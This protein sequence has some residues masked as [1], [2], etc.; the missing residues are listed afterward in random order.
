M[1][2]RRKTAL[3]A[4][5][6]TIAVLIA[7]N[8][9]WW[10]YYQSISSYLETQL[11]RRLTGVAA[12]VALHIEPLQVEDLLLD[13]L[14]TYAEV[15]MYL[16]SLATIDSLSEASIIDIDF[17]YL[18]SSRLD[19]PSQGYLLARTNF[20][21]LQEAIGG[22]PTASPLYNVDGTYLKSAYAPLYGIDSTVAAL[23]VTEAGA[24]Y[25]TLLEAL[26]GNLF[27][28]A[29]GSAAAVAVL[30]VI[31]ILFNRRLAMAEERIIQAGTQAALGR[32]VAVVSH[33]VKNPLMI[34]RAAGERLGKKYDDP[35]ASFIVEEVARLDSIVTGYL[36]FARGDLSLN[37]EMVSLT[38]II[39]QI[40]RQFGRQ[41]AE[42]SVELGV[43]LEETE[44][45]LPADNVALRQVLINLLLNALQAAADNDT[46]EQKMVALSAK[47]DGRF[48]RIAVSDT[49]AGIPSAQ[50]SK[51]FE[52]FYTT[53][54]SG[55]G[56]G[57]YLTRRLVEAMGGKI[58]LS[59]DIPNRTTF[60]IRLPRG[61]N[62]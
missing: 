13:N 25:F 19:R 43:T 34:L 46:A 52:P 29:G 32:M 28:L 42:K 17:N 58:A 12:G 56:L 40:V 54:A 55:T 2:I 11:S 60:E 39:D 7:V 24:G 51:L 6:F 3:A 10:W 47:S 18:V 4:I 14:D 62:G 30:L 1:R 59:D 37:I 27:L 20:T 50:R 36:K 44:I 35:E 21:Q 15:L 23:V 5:V 26:R 57:L 16:D 22:R 53:K 45:L 31:F 41:F 49:G 9:G 61:E 38:E 8:I 48:V 33:E